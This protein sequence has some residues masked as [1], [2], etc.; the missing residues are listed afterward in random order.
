MQKVAQTVLANHPAIHLIEPLDYL[1]FVYLMRRAYLLVT[2][3]AACRRKRRRSGKPVL[4]TRDTTE[5]PEAVEAGTV[6]L[7]GTEHGNSH[8]SRKQTA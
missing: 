6:E 7:V 5:R 4:V 1:P 2:D 8:H 3:S